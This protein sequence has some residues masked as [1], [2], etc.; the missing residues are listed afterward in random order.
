[1]KTLKAPTAVETEKYWFADNPSLTHFMHSLSVLFPEGERFFLRATT[2]YLDSVPELRDEVIEFCKQEASHG[3]MHTAM[4]A[5]AVDVADVLKRLESDTKLLLDIVSEYSTPRM[6][7]LITICLEHITSI[8]GNKLLERY[9]ITDMMT[10][11]MR[12]AW[13]YHSLE[14]VE[15]AH[16]AFDVYKATGGTESERIVMMPFVTVGLAVVVAR[17]WS[18]ILKEDSSDGLLDAIKILF[19]RKGFVT[20]LIPNYFKWYKP[21]FH[22]KHI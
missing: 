6:R 10:E 4:N 20:S 13:T 11:T 16:V 1:M 15:H 18:V 22:P 12:D 17:Y 5:N 14:E 7:M 9:D 2:H 8:L 3:R 19:G 21:K